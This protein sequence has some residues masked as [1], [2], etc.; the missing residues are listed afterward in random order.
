[1]K[2]EDHDL[3]HCLHRILGPARSSH[4]PCSVPARQRLRYHLGARWPVRYPRRS[5]DGFSDHL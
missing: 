4:H 2:E 1:M 3:H 5:P